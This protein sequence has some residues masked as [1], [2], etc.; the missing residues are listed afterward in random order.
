MLLTVATVAGDLF[1]AVLVV[2]DLCNFDDV[3]GI[4][5]VLMAFL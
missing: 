2:R 3:L 1:I 4:Y 5:V